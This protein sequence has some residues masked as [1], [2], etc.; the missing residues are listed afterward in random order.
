VSGELA[1]TEAKLCFEP[2]VHGEAPM[3]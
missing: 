2:W 3:R 1:V